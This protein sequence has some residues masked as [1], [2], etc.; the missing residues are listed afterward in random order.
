M[1]LISFP[2]KPLKFYSNLTIAYKGSDPNIKKDLYKVGGVYGIVFNSKKGKPMQY[3]GSSLNLYERVMDHIKNRDSNIRL[4]RRIAKHGIER[5]SLV[6]YY[7]DK[8]PAILLTDI[9]TKVISSFP[10]EYLF[11]FK[12]LANSLLGYKHSQRAKLKMKYRLSI[13]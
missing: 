5:F 3:I 13:K 12:R 8:D 7:F 10:F 1:Y 11:N 2:I 9:E 4:Q 6:I